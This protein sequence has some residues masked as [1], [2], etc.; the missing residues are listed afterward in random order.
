MNILVHISSYEHLRSYDRREQ[1]CL[2]FA[3]RCLENPKLTG[4]FPR[5][6]K[7]HEMKTRDSEEFKVQFANTTRLKN[8]PIIY[9]QRLLNSC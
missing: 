7:I 9:M 2:N 1:L 8:S 3:K 6:E 5:N 4:I